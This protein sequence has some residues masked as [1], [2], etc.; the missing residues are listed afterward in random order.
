M[1]VGEC[2]KLL[3]LHTKGS[4]NIFITTLSR[5][6]MVAIGGL[7]PRDFNRKFYSDR[8]NGDNK[9]SQLDVTVGESVLWRPELFSSSQYSSWAMAP[10][11]EA[12]RYLKVPA[13]HGCSFTFAGW[14]GLRSLGILSAERSKK[15][16]TSLHS[17]RRMC[18]PS[19]HRFKMRFC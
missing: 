2:A 7:D 6:P 19:S 16:W 9:F 10:T 11:R 15:G 5:S 12:H 1:A 3:R 13:K 4:G 17:S 18:R 14:R 8:D